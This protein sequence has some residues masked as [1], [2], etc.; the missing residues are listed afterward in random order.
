MRC[1]RV[2]RNKLRFCKRAKVPGELTDLAEQSRNSIA[3]RTFGNQHQL[4]TGIC[5]LTHER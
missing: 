1:G 3:K 4:S 2:W 5:C